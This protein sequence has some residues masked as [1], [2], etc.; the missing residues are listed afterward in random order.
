MKKII[1][2]LLTLFVT[3]VNAQND[4]FVVTMEKMITELDSA[5][6][7]N[8]LQ[9]SANKFERIANANSKEWLPLYYQSLSYVRILMKKEDNSA[10][11]EMYDRAELLIN[12]GD[13]IS[14][15][16][17][18]VYVVKSLIM[19]MRVSVDPA[20]RG[21]KHGRQASMLNSKAVELNMDNLRAYY[22]KG[23][24][25]MYTPEQFGGA[26]AR[27]QPVLEESIAKYKTFIPS[28]SIMPNWGESQ[29]NEALTRCKNM[30]Q[31][32]K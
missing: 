20:S 10:K 9:N 22:L 16:N 19:A 15:D 12:K 18:E 1:F 3:I 11:D 29:A 17:S 2:Y 5:G 25:L 21:Q 24:G 32:G 31:N 7:F 23:Q 14:Q 13:S 28:S 27:A 6:D 26:A 8:A 4:K 30:L